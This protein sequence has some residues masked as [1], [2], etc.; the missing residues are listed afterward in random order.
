MKMELIGTVWIAVK[1]CRSSQY[2]I[3][4]VTFLEYFSNYGQHKYHFEICIWHLM[5]PIN[6]AVWSERD[7]VD[8]SAVL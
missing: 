2:I 1:K 3:I 6:I 5:S 8:N 4:E 7:F